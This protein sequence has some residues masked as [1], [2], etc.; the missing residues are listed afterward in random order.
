MGTA[1]LALL[2]SVSRR[3]S[4]TRSAGEAELLCARGVRG[5][6]RGAA[7]RGVRA[8][9]EHRRAERRG[10]RGPTFARFY[11]HHHCYCYYY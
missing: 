2:D 11:H 8:V 1:A 4:W 6:G 3:E 7:E 10:L 5:G 9:H